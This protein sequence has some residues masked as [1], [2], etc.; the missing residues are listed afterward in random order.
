MAIFAICDSA[1][2]NVM[3]TAAIKAAKGLV[4]DFGELEHLQVSRKGLGDFVSVADKR[5][6]KT[7]IYELSKARPDYN[8]ITE[9][10][11]E[12]KILIQILHG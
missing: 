7:L 9:E 3:N 11:G 10:T 6:E 2:I 5:C 4:R 1:I 12:I 8:F